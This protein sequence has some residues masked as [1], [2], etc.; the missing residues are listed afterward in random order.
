PLVGILFIMMV[1][2]AAPAFLLMS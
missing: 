2:V 1:I